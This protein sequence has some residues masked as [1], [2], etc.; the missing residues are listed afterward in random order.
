MCPL[1]RSVALH[2]MFQLE[3]GLSLDAETPNSVS[4][5]L[6]AVVVVVVG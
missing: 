5:Q 3:G 6:V 4:L 1:A 2:K